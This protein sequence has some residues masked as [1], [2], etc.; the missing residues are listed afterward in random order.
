MAGIC[1]VVG[2]GSD[3]VDALASDLQWTGDERIQATRED[4]LGVVVATHPASTD[5]QPASTGDVTVWCWGEVYG[6]DGP[7]GYVSCDRPPADFIAEL[8]DRRGRRAF[9]DVNG[10]FAAVVRGGDR[11]EL[12]TDRLGTR[13]FYYTRIDGGVVFST[14]I[15]SLDRHPAVTTGFD[16]DFVT[17]YLACKRAYGVHTPLSGVTQTQPAAVS[18]VD[19][20]GDGALAH[21]RYWRPVHRPVDRPKSYFVRE[22]ADRFERAVAER[23]SDRGRTGV[24][25][26]GGS[27]SRLVL[28]ALDSL[29]RDATMFHLNEWENAE[30]DIARESAATTDDEFVFCRRDPDYQARALER[31][32]AMMNFVGY[33]NQA[34]AAGFED[35]IRGRVDHLLTG[36]YG[37][38]LFKGNHLPSKT[39]SLGPLGEMS[40]PTGSIETVDEYVDHRASDAPPFLAGR[41]P[42]QI[43]AENMHAVDGRV[44]DHGVEYDS[45]REALLAS[46]SPL[47][48]G[49]SQFF[50][51]GTAQS[52]PATTPFLDTRLVDLF[53]TIP[54]SLL[55]H[56]GLVNAAVERLSP[57]LAEIP[58]GATGQPLSRSYPAQYAGKYLTALKRKRASAPPVAH[59]THGPWTAHDDLVRERE[60]VHDCVDRNRDLFET[61]PFLDWDGVQQQLR[62]QEA[63]A[64]EFGSLYA[65][66]SFLEMPVTRRLATTDRPSVADRAR[67]D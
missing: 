3:A 60:F 2:E 67:A 15:Q 44:V 7:T 18:V 61:L 21:Q 37:D 57:A 54:R 16:P 20:G 43:L 66:V 26:S 34:H 64:N 51:F 32:P 47:T 5:P 63:G 39:V 48:N 14:H 41:S 29:G 65:L 31:N 46:R 9:A 27:D 50:Y 4:G 8:Y 30:Y 28:A 25:L 10:L 23:T 40:V 45:I 19:P 52:I 58:H 42:R 49:T 11:V 22:L 53:L 6:Y 1:G 62:A 56:G 59:G 13:P 35:E 55:R 36:H 17:E 12:V 33:F 38:M 24:L